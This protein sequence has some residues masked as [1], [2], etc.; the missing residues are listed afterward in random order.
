M[1]KAIVW[2][3]VLAVAGVLGWMIYDR[4]NRQKAEKPRGS[5]VTPVV[6][7]AVDRATVRDIQTFTGTLEPRQQFVVSP[8]TP[9]KLETLTVDIGDAVESGQVIATLDDAEYQRLVA[10]AQAEKAVAEAAVLEA[11]SACDVKE[12]EFKRIGALKDKGIASEAALD[13]AEGE[14]KVAQA[15]VQS[16]KEQV[17]QRDEAL[18]AARI[19]LGYTQIKPEWKDGGTYVVGERFANRGAQLQAVT[20]IV[21][22]LDLSTVKAVVYVTEREYP[23]MHVTQAVTVTTDAYPKRTFEG[24]VVRLAP[25]V[26][27]T[28]RQ[29]RVEIEIAN[30]D[31]V[32]KA[33]M[34]VRAQ[35][36]FEKHENALVVP[37]DAVVRR[38]NQRGVFLADLEKKKVTFVAVEEGISEGGRTEV[39]QPKDLKGSVVTLGQHL[40]EDGG[41]IVLAKEGDGDE[42]AKH[43]PSSQNDSGAQAPNGATKADESKGS[44]AS[45]ASSGATTSEPAPGATGGAAR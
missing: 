41:A 18:L 17:N 2:L 26:K 20:P 16:A 10:Q 1:K 15:K 3:V 40:L 12:K 36:E 31:R 23:K 43:P 14:F 9:G 34:Y 42:A 29:A 13:A 38:G 7:T 21:S 30:P 19:R 25:L 11:Q 33:G 24:R 39:L 37:S 8:K 45:P 28:S 35:V 44:N 27:E 5:G 32:L 22:L 6:V 4:L